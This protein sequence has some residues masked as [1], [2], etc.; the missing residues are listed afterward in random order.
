MDEM[1]R[2]GLNYLFIEIVLL[3]VKKFAIKTKYA[4]LDA[5]SFHKDISG[6]RK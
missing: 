4:H 1:Y 5:T 3:V 6:K 2:F